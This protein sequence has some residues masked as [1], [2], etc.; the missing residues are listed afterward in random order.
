MNGQGTSI[1]WPKIL[2]LKLEY[3]PIRLISA[4]K[5]FLT[6]SGVM[7]SELS[8][9]QQSAE[10]LALI[11]AGDVKLEQMFREVKIFIPMEELERN[12]I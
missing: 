4:S 8:N 3:A 7:F 6:S 10:L 11:H 1:H 12:E 2:S 9:R 5:I